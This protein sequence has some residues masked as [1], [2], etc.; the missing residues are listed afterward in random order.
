MKFNGFEIDLVGALNSIA[1]LI[2]AIGALVMAFK[3]I[4]KRKDGKK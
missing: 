2:T 3:G 4:N 1:A